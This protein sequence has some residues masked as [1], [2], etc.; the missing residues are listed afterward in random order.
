MITPPIMFDGD[1]AHAW[2]A[3]NRLL[4]LCSVSGMG[5]YTIDFDMVKQFDLDV[6]NWDFF[7]RVMEI[8]HT[9]YQAHLMR[10]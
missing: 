6:E 10:K 4:G 3:Y 5:G 1:V 8:I 9:K 2:T 7:W